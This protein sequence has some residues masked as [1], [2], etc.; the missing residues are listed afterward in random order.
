MIYDKDILIGKWVSG[1]ISPE[2]ENWLM[3][4]ASQ[5]MANQQEL[6]LARKV[7]D[8]SA[9]LK[10][11]EPA[12]IELAW[13]DL[14]KRINSGSSKSKPVL[15]WLPVAASLAAIIVMGVIV[16]YFFFSGQPEV[17]PLAASSVHIDT[18]LVAEQVPDTF[19]MP[20]PVTTEQTVADNLSKGRKT[21]MIAVSAVDSALVFT[22]PDKSV[23][24]LNKNSKL[25]YPEKFT[26]S[27]RT[28]NLS[29]EAYFEV[30]KNKGEFVVICQD[31][32]TRVLGTSF[33]VRGYQPNNNVEVTVITGLVEVTNAS[34]K[35]YGRQLLLKPG[36]QAVFNAVENTAVRAKHVKK[37]K[38]WKRSNFRSKI[39][40]F[41][42][43]IVNKKAG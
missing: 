11:N 36:E 28:V 42:N 38:W 34:K 10:R 30:V 5:S 32:K 37:D 13:G 7:W 40:Q 18:V 17:L 3:A 6:D 23:V 21:A 16:K 8:S 4:W 25:T 12:D 2:E 24:Y 1:E 35:V 9:A 15:R 14:Q 31:T 20:A 27:E 41:F 22:L 26:G 39:K 19:K 43:K 33:N 29:G